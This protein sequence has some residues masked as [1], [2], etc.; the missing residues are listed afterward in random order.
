MGGSGGGQTQTTSTEP[1]SLVRPYLANYLGLGQ[2]TL[3]PG[4]NGQWQIAPYPYPNQEVAPF[5]GMQMGGFDAISAMGGRSPLVDQAMQFQSNVMNQDA[6][7]NPLLS[8]YFNR[9]AGDV[10]GQMNSAAVRAG[11][12]G[13]SGATET[14]GKTMN[15][16]ATSIY[17]PAW[18][19]QE[20]LRQNA[21]GMAP[22][23]MQSSYF[24]SQMLLEAGGQQQAQ[25]QNVLNTAYQ[26]L[27]GQQ[28]W[29]F[30][31]LQMLAQVLGIGQGLGSTATV[32]VK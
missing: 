21:A 2:N 13:G 30:D 18:Q 23:L 22:G 10:M 8:D 1:N 24:P 17:F 19:E 3:A 14:A 16:L 9:A 7:N 4:A 5:S 11:A 26:N 31:V 25:A 32:K 6:A 20:R 15:D 29:P 12:Y 28:G 27:Y